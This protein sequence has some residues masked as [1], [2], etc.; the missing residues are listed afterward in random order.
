MPAPQLLAGALELALNKV[1][2]L[3]NASQQRLAPLCGKRMRVKLKELPW[4]LTFVFSSQIDLLMDDEQPV[5]CAMEL[6]LTHLQEMQD[7]ANISALIQD[8]KLS[9]NGDMH[10]AQSFAAL[11]KE[12]DI[13]WE[14]QLS[15]YTGDVF[16]HQSVQLAKSLH[17]R[18]KGHLQQLGQIIKDGALHEKQLAAHPLAVED[19]SRDV[20]KLRADTARFEARLS[21]LEQLKASR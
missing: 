15:R 21:Q 10:T 3:D 18:A 1:L 11:L 7:P 12:L 6:S 2:S 13:D 14:E 9:L 4:P 17:Q 19:F 5:D 20:N 8:K 16:A